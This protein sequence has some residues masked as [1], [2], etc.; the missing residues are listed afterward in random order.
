MLVGMTALLSVL[1]TAF[2]QIIPPNRLPTWQG[3]VG[4]P[5]GIPN[6]TTVYTTIAA[7][8]S[9]ATI[10]SAIN[11]CPSNQ[12]VLLSAGTY[13]LTTSLSL[14]SGVTLR[15]AG[16]DVTIL[17]TSVNNAIQTLAPF[18]DD[19]GSPVKA[20]HISWIGNYT[21]NTNVLM[22]AS[23]NLS[24]GAEAISAG[25]IVM[26]D[27]QSDANCDATGGYGLQGVWWSIA[28]PSSGADRY[29]HQISYVTAKNGHS[30]TIDPPIHM[31]NYNSAALPQVWFEASS[32][33]IMYAGVENLT[34][35]NTGGS[36]SAHGFNAQYAYGC[37]IK[38]C[39]ESNFRYGF[40]TSFAVRCEWRHCY[41]L[42]SGTGYVDDYHFSLYYC[43][44]CLFEDNITED[45]YESG[46]LMESVTGSAFAYNYSTNCHSTTGGN[47]ASGDCNSHGGNNSMNLLEGN[48]FI[49]VSLDNGWGSAYGFVLLR[50]RIRGWDEVGSNYGNY[51]AA[52]DD[53]SMNR[54]MNFAG[55]VLGTSGKNTTYESHSTGNN[56][57]WLTQISISGYAPSPD[58][59]VSTSMIRAM[60]WDSA[61][62]TNGGLVSAGY[63]SGDLPA[64]FLY[65][66]KPSYFGTL[67]WPPVDPTQ[68]AY[69]S[70]I[71]NLPAGYRRVYGADP[72]AGSA[73]QPPVAVAGATP[74]SGTAPLTVTFSSTGSYDP[75]GVTL[76]YAW[77]FGD[78][79]TSTAA[80]PSHTYQAAGTYSASL[81]V[82]DGVNTTT[83]SNITIK[84]SSA[85]SNQPPIANA[86]ATPTSGAAPLLVS[87]SSAG[88]SDPE[89]AALT[90]NWTFGDGTTST[91]ANPTHTYSNAGA[92]IA[93]L[94]VSDGTNATASAILN[95]SVSVAGNPLPAVA[96]DFYLD[97]EAGTNGQPI[98]TN[99][100]ASCTHTTEGG[101]WTLNRGHPQGCTDCFAQLPS[102]TDFVVLT[103]AG[104]NGVWQLRSPVSV[105]G[106]T[107]NDATHTR[108]FGK[109]M[110][111]LNQGAQFNFATPHWQVSMGYYYTMAVGY[112]ND[113]IGDILSTDMYNYTN[114][115]SWD[116]DVMGGSIMNYVAEVNVHSQAGG[117]G[118]VVQDNIAFSK[119]YW[120]S[121]LWDG[122]NG[123]C[124]VAVYD[125]L[126]WTQV[127]S[128]S[129]LTLSNMPCLCVQF[130][131]FDPTN[132]PT[133][134]VT[135]C[136][137]NLVMDWNTATFPLLLPAEGP[138]NQAPV[139]VASATPV[140]GVAPLS[141][142][143]SSA[144]SADPEGAA[145]TYNWIFGDGT[146]STAA[147]PTHI[148]EAAG[149]YTASL[150]VSDGTNQ[151]TSSPLTITAGNGGSGLVAAYGFEEGSGSTVSDT[152]G[153]GN[154]GTVSGGAWTTAGRYGDALVFN[155]TNTL[156]TINDA[157]SLHLGS[158]LTLE[159][160]VN[161]SAL[162]SWKNLIYKPQGSTGISYVLQG[163][164]SSTQVPSLGMSVCSA[165]LMAPN[166]L[167]LNTWSHVAATYD[168]TTMTFYVNGTQVSSQAQTGTITSTT[169][170]LTIGGNSFYG[171]NWAGIIDEVRIYNRA[172]S[173]SEI[174]TD[175]QTPVVQRPTA[176]QGLHVVV[177][178]Q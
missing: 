54:F 115:G 171:E 106:V 55:N 60:N 133:F 113:Y 98:T 118:S 168:G 76:S 61:T 28:N 148:Y 75:E 166:P 129:Q 160:W 67:A 90:Y 154:N 65:S 74:T 19:F 40:C 175:M 56:L 165:N 105:N 13:T 51:V 153:N 9:T 156:V 78:G 126:T 38:N 92:Y 4:V 6:R 22:L 135:N 30:I 111:D 68:V 110:H 150:T 8:A 27:Q 21:Q 120:I 35:H 77:T 7:G 18:S 72:A 36:N 109:G 159:A 64:S 80:N 47:M 108:V 177:V 16:M 102:V 107:Y 103:S 39:K 33:P 138:V 161:P 46:F 24:G 25:N 99:L 143:F 11:A 79:A 147:N 141:V 100:L 173:T 97:M 119:T 66:S 12:V 89:G 34:L 124:K 83:S 69:S 174:Q 59:V 136:F 37:W 32:G 132:S 44:G 62:S 93:Q 52:I 87:F 122:L 116:F 29:Q 146:T 149:V 139:A 142:S 144:G 121:Q 170:A 1:E 53:Y 178:T 128:T 176:P 45:K 112:N 86:S 91:A 125:P 88:S 81:Q 155:G 71:T 85:G 23:T 127:G 63:T 169:D 5:G 137:G 167:P 41:A 163:S 164:S 42:G 49:Q 95:I 73:N 152:S 130:G 20:N 14:K 15:G 10:Q 2:C 31:A 101:Y 157:A 17:N 48:S 58:P 96:V 131:E 43:G 94:T 162:G 82:S 50:N 123:V 145:L 158:A 140:S 114:S 151:T 57:V 84:V 3:N 117:T 70:S 172:L 104:T 26:I 134:A